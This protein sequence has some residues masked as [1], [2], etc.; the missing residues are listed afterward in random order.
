MKLYQCF[1]V[2]A[3][4]SGYNWIESLLCLLYA[5]SFDIKQ[6]FEFNFIVWLGKTENQG[7]S[8]SSINKWMSD[9]REYSC[10]ATFSCLEWVRTEGQMFKNH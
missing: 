4:I 8:K 5:I 3:A 1:H 9:A 7:R 6:Q 10:I 2:V